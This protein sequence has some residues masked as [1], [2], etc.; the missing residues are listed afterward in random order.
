VGPPGPDRKGGCPHRRWRPASPQPGGLPG[1]P[2]V[3][4]GL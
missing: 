2:A 3:S 1:G 4:G